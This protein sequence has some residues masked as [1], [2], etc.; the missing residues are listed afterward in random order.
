M[1]WFLADVLTAKQVYFLS[2][3]LLELFQTLYIPQV[4]LQFELELGCATCCAL[5]ELF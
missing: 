3:C 4:C 1:L 5:Y 2:A